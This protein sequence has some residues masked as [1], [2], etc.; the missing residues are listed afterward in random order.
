MKETRIKIMFEEKLDKIESKLNIILKGKK[1][2][3][4]YLS[5]KINENQQEIK[6]LN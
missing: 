5:K 3:W 2:Y 6:D 1:D 4:E